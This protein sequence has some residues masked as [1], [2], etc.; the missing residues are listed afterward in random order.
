M[1][2]SQRNRQKIVQIVTPENEKLVIFGSFFHDIIKY[3]ICDT[4]IS[5]LFFTGMLLGW[6][7][8]MACMHMA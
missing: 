7:W 6:F 4:D 5:A 2:T 3:M 8:Y 1:M